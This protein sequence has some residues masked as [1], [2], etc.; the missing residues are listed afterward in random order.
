MIIGKPELWNQQQDFLSNNA[1][2][3][4]D[5]Q[6]KGQTEKQTRRQTDK[7]QAQKLCLLC[8]LLWQSLES[9]FQKDTFKGWCFQY[10][11]LYDS[12]DCLRKSKDIHSWYI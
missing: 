12:T 11:S 6:Q 7:G 1:S 8:V 4:K 5:K 3:Q 9:K 2:R 10:V